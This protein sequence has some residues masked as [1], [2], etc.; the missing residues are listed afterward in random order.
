MKKSMVILWEMLLE[1]IAS[2]VSAVPLSPSKMIHI[3]KEGLFVLKYALSF[4]VFVCVLFLVVLAILYIPSSIPTVG[5]TEVLSFSRSTPNDNGPGSFLYLI[6]I[7]GLIGF[8]IG[9]VI[10]CQKLKEKNLYRVYK[11]VYRK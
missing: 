2:L 7:A 11:K 5:E 6:W 10:G 3:G 1:S 8:F 9:W 4:A